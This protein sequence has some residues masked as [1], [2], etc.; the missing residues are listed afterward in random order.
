MQSPPARR[1]A[2]RLA[3]IM[4]DMKAEEADGYYEEDEDPA[5]RA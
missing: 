3:G 5:K 2:D 4:A 1:L